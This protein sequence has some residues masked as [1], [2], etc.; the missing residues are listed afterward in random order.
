MGMS[1]NVFAAFPPRHLPLAVVLCM[2]VGMKM[3]S[4]LR[5]LH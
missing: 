1:L 5:L 4:P 2:D 3:D